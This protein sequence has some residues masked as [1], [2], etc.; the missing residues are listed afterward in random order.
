[1]TRRNYCGKCNEIVYDFDVT[2]GEC[3]VSLHDSCAT[4]Y[5]IMSRMA[6]LQAKYNVYCEPKFN[7]VETQ[8]MIDDINSSTFSTYIQSTFFSDIYDE[9]YQEMQKTTN[10]QDFTEEQCTVFVEQIMELITGGGDLLDFKCNM[11]HN[12]I[13]INKYLY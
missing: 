12:N 3:G 2:C 10:V 4:S 7:K 5:D 11:C 1:M 13:R 8:Q 6:L 9:L